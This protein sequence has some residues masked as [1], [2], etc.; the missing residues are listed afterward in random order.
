MIVYT[1]ETLADAIRDLLPR[2]PAYWDEIRTEQDP[3]QV[4]LSLDTYA[5]LERQEALLYLTARQ[6][7]RATFLGCILAWCL[8]H[9]RH[10]DAQR[11]GFVQAWWVEPASRRTQI[12]ATL[13][14][15]LEG[16]LVARGI[17]YCYVSTARRLNV[18]PLLT[19][20][21][22][23]PTETMYVKDLQECTDVHRC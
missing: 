12:G 7:E 5:A 9:P 6:R 13:L 18:A 20:A 1:Q 8:P 11:M 16:H 14:R 2:L 22:W 23:M 10:V 19:Q 17:R 3:P 4:S 21:G 15:C